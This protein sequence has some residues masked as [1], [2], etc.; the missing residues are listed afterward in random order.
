MPGR[1]VAVI[2][3]HTVQQRLEKIAIRELI[4]LSAVCRRLIVAGLQQQ[5]DAVEP[6]RVDQ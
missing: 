4:S 6:R 2:L 3:P 5:S 1:A